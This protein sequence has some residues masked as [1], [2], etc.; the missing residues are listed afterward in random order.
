MV[1]DRVIWLGSFLKDR[2]WD[3]VIINRFKQ[4]YEHAELVNEISKNLEVK[5]EEHFA[6]AGFNTISR[7]RYKTS[8]GQR[9]DFDVLA[10]KDNTIFICEVKS[11]WRSD[12]FSYATYL[13]VN[14]LEGCA[15]D[16]LE[17]GLAHL[18]EDWGTIRT[19]LK[20]NKN[21][22][23]EEITVIPIIVT[24]YFEGD[25]LLYRGV[26]RKISLLEL[27]V[28]FKNSKRQL[29]ETY[30]WMKQFLDQNNPNLNADR[31]P[32]IAWNLRDNKQNIDVATM[33]NII[34]DNRIWI[35]LEKFWRFSPVTYSI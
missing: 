9:G 33:L 4:E 2:R 6:S 11:G 1:D 20:I 24:D 5:I 3:N 30:F 17:K 28:I 21:I 14:R 12:D 23:L 29:L 7:L 10:F 16:Q 25:N 34:D 15:A 27:E 26:C 19:K 35:E 13:E 8:D 32:A 22:L 31:S 18:P